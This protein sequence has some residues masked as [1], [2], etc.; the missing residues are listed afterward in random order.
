MEPV[1]FA[2]V[3]MSLP[4]VAALMEHFDD[5]GMSERHHSH[6]DTYMV[7][8]ALSRSVVA[9]MAFAAIMGIVLSWLCNVGVFD[10]SGGVVPGF[11]LSYLVA[12]FCMWAMMRRYRVVTYDD[13]M[14]VTPLVGP[15][16]EVRYSDIT[17]IR[18]MCPLGS[19]GST[20]VRVWAH[21]RRAATIWFAVDVEQ[22]LMR[23]DRFDVLVG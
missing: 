11:F 5:S 20:S 16:A 10:V 6:H 9:S 14:A 23:I 17:S 15:T 21:G 1:L 13:R 7:S 19:A 18:R 22:I 8:G 2:T 12:S 3:S 4:I